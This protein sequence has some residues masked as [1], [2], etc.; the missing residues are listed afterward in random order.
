MKPAKLLILA[1]AGLL[2]V[3]SKRD[4]LEAADDDMVGQV[5]GGFSFETLASRAEETI[6]VLTEQAAD[7][8]NTTAQNNIAAGLKVIRLAEGTEGQPDPWRVCY[9]YRHTIQDTSSHPAITG[10]WMG[11]L[12]PD[13]MC[14]NAGFGPGCKS[15]AAGAYQI[16]K[17][18]YRDVS[19]KTGVVGFDRASQDTYAISLIARCGALEDLKAGNVAEFVRKCRG[20]WASLPGN[21][22]KQGQRTYAQ[23]TLWFQQAGGQLA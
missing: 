21:S 3:A 12:L 6:N 2:L 20:R 13:E 4:D 1:S 5:A 14:A 18:T 17:V 22:A 8:D 16:N 10:E 15:T 19:A 23:L 7:V 9:G 11:E